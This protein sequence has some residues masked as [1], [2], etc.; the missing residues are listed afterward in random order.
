MKPLQFRL[1]L[2]L[3]FCLLAAVV[4]A[5]ALLGISHLRKLNRQMEN[6]IYDRWQEV[7]LSH[8]AYSLSTEN[9]RLTILVFLL[10]D[11]E[12]I[13]QMLAERSGNT[14]RISELSKILDARLDSPEEKAKF[15]VVKQ[16]RVRYVESYKKALELLL[17]KNR[18]EEAKRMMVEVVTPN[19]VQ[20]YRAWLD[21]E[22]EESRQVGLAVE[23]SRNDYL[24]SQN[25]ILITLLLAVV[26]TAMIGS[27]TIWRTTREVTVR[28]QAEA[29]LRQAHDQLEQRVQ[30]RTAELER[31]NQ[32]LQQ[33]IAERK[34]AVELL[35][36][37]EARFSTAFEN[38]AVGEALVE[39]CGRFIKINRAFTR[40]TGYTL[41]DL[42]EKT[43]R[44]ITHP[45]DAKEN[46][47]Y[48]I[49][50]LANEIQAFQMEKRYIHKNGH[51]IWTLLSV[52]LI[53]D[54]DGKPVHF[55]AQVQDIHER[56]QATEQLDRMFALSPDMIFTAG[57]DGYLRQIN[58][59]V[60][61]VL[62]LSEKELLAEPFQVH[63]HPD[64]RQAVE[65][66]IKR[67]LAEGKHLGFE[68]R[69]LRKDGT[70]RWT[71]CN[72]VAVHSEQLFYVVGRD[73][74]E[75]KESQEQLER[76]RSEHELLLNSLGEGVHWVDVDGRIKYENPAAAKMLGYEAADL[77]GRPAHATMHHTRANGDNYPLSECNIYAT[78]RD[79]IARRAT[80]EVFWRK[81]GTSFP[82]EYIATAIS[83]KDGKSGGAV[84]IFT[85]ITERR[86]A[87]SKLRE[88]HNQ[89]LDTSRRAGMAE[90][91]TSVLHNVGNVLNSINVSSALVSDIIRKSKMMNLSKACAMMAEHKGNIGE[92]FTNDVKGKQLPGYLSQLAEHLV[93]EQGLLLRELGL[94]QKNIDHIKQIIGMQQRYAKISGI[95]ETVSVLD[96]VDEALRMQAAGMER[97]GV[98][99][100]TECEEMLTITVEKHK[101][102]QILVNLLHNAKH[103]CDATEKKDRLIRVCIFPSKD[104]DCQ[105]VVAISVSD[106]GIGISQENLTRIFAYGF[107]TR[108]SGHGFGL[109]SGALAAREMG[110]YLSADSAGLGKGAVFTLRLPYAPPKRFPGGVELSKME[111]SVTV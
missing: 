57:F 77:V 85:D 67:V 38:A 91:A 97:H 33:E 22:N 89:L 79:G 100:R 47:E 21:F 12:L 42:G 58:P 51:F 14:D 92:F 52:S 88:L 44:E 17:A 68:C 102:L 60:E 93:T 99:V 50:V 53:R 46:E 45:D 28:L 13:Q 8:E 24:A 43:F 70:I 16:T 4:A 86:R 32:A 20:Y 66:S 25:K 36:I 26:L 110:G 10:Q 78:L 39:P 49:R 76:I 31:S 95:V 101:L 34:R 108:S 23:Q 105:N 59:A 40:L 37:G 62:G 3:A 107:T 48:V 87:E 111:L 84:V 83:G 103:A 90:V 106:N 75:F 56:K 30:E 9:S 82:V 18:G 71:Q 69:N 94:L 55:I 54:A 65:D 63:I 73:I 27:S 7:Q 98:G 1:R 61:R 29:A 72:T 104:E 11:K 15:A 6:D 19:L 5:V 96:I 109:H 64:D 41:E 74:T 80:D 35:R 81:D 2:I